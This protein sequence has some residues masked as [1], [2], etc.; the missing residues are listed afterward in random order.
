MTG[1]PPAQM[2]AGS[3]DAA[4]TLMLAALIAARGQAD[5]TTV[6]GAQIRDALRA[7]SDT[8]GAIVRTGTP[9]LTKA[10]R[11][12][13]EGSAI[14]YEGASGP[15]DY[16][17]NG[18]VTTRIARFTVVSGTFA[19]SAIFDCVQDSSCPAL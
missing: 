11:L 2:D 5:P 12:I 3:Y 6:T 9:E 7:T 1:L 14:N 13:G 17:A 18:N 19:D 4:V 15:C 10:V 16:D 8:T